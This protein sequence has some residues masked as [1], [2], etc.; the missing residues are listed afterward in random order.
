MSAARTPIEDCVC[1]GGAGVGRASERCV[2]VADGKGLR[3]GTSGNVVVCGCRYVGG[4]W[5]GKKHGKGTFTAAD[6]ER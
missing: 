4:F 6:G 3:V 2:V 5:H 1:P